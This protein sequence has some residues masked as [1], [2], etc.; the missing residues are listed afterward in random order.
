MSLAR[1]ASAEFAG[2]GLLVAAVVGSGIA[3]GSVPGFVA[4][5]LVGGLAAVAAI[6]WWYPDADRTAD[7]AADAV[8]VPHT[9]EA[10][11]R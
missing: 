3:P 8:L 9:G 2:T 1:R 5:Q 4:A 11:D 7:T 6:A 10:V